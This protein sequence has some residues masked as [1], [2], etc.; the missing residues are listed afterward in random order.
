MHDAF[1]YRADQ[2]RKYVK[3]LP[4]T[5]F[6][7]GERAQMCELISAEFRFRDMPEFASGPIERDE[8]VFTQGSERVSVKTYIP[9]KGD[10][11]MFRL[12]HT[13]RPGVPPPPTY[14]IEDGLLSRKH[15][16]D[17]R[18]LDTLDRDVEE[19]IQMVQKYLKPVREMI[20]RFNESLRGVAEEAFNHRAHE[21]SQNKQ[22]MEKL[23]QS[24]MPLRKR[25]DGAEKIIVP[26][27]R[28][29]LRVAA[30]SVSKVD[31]VREYVLGMAE[32]EEI[33][34]TISSMAKVMERTPEVFA[35]MNEEPLRTILLV[36]LNGIY[37]G[38]ATGETF[39]GHGK[40]DI[41]IRKEDKNVF[42]AECL[43]WDGQAYLQKKMDGQLFRYAM[44]R[45]SKLALI[46][47]N[48]GGN[49]TQV[50]EKMK[51]T[52][53]AHAQCINEL[54]YKHESGA[55]YVFR[56]DEDAARHFTLTALAFDV[57]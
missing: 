13:T 29:Q 39:N 31:A 25:S 21:V 33:L 8:P 35:E 7:V 22:A 51:A 16:L 4:D 2:I 9:Y 3:K 10:V 55:R 50:I 20:P 49:F 47:F 54:E 37:E 34:S 56:R 11:S 36:A 28:K 24:K 43:M 14:E 41:L 48:R 26:V 52:I 40:A 12:Y 5:D 46:V 1:Q 6:D 23:A 30:A 57:P 45:D 53:K 42:I 15:V 38:Q 17:K 18:H 19:E 44:W 27:E 32:Y